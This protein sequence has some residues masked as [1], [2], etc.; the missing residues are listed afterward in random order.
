MTI[1]LSKADFARHVNR[2]R[3]CISGWLKTGK[4][5]SEAIVDGKIDRDRALADLAA[6]LDP[7][8]QAAQTSPIIGSSTIST[9]ARSDPIVNPIMAEREKDQARRAKAD[10]D[11]AEHDAEAARRK[12]A[13]DE[14]K[15]VVAEE[16]AASFGREMAKF[17]SETELFINNLA[18]RIAENHNLDHK[19]I[20]AFA[21]EDYRKF[22]GEYS[23]DA[24]AR[25]A[26]LRA[27][28]KDGT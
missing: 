8:Q 17:I 19:Q 10:A 16:A 6:S 11:R 23:A 12:L 27:K 14:G 24:G 9:E 22:R 7:G 21:R 15:Y 18:R 13:L 20:T 2:S 5:S 26:A 25:L 28:K 4:I 3:A 1:F